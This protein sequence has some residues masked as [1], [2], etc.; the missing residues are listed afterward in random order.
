MLKSLKKKNRIFSLDSISNPKPKVKVDNTAIRSVLECKNL[1]DNCNDSFLPIQVPQ[2]F[3]Q[4]RKVY[5]LD[6]LGTTGKGQTVV[7]YGVNIDEK[8][9]MDSYIGFDQFY[10]FNRP[11]TL[12]IKFITPNQIASPSWTGEALGD[13]QCIHAMAPDAK[14]ILVSLDYNLF[15]GSFGQFGPFPD[16]SVAIQYGLSFKP[17]VFS[18][19]VGWQEED[20][21]YVNYGSGGGIPSF[22]PSF[23]PSLP[24]DQLNYKYFHT[25]TGVDGSERVFE[26]GVKDGIVFVASSG[27]EGA[28]PNYPSTSPNVV[29]VG[30]SMLTTLA[31]NKHL[32]YGTTWSGGGPSTWADK[33]EYQKHI[34]GKFRMTPDVSA[35]GELIWLY[36]AAS[37][38]YEPF[39]YFGVG[40]GTSASA[41]LWAGIL[42]SLN[43]A[44]IK[45]SLQKFNTKTLLSEIY[46]NRQV[47][48]KFYDITKVTNLIPGLAGYTINNGTFQGDPN[49]WNYGNLARFVEQ[50]WDM[51][52]GWGT[53]RYKLLEFLSGGESCHKK[54][55]HKSDCDHKTNTISSFISTL[56]EWPP[57]FSGFPIDSTDT[58]PQ[59]ILITRYQA[60]MIS[61]YNDSSSNIGAGSS[62]ALNFLTSNW[63]NTNFGEYYQFTDP[64][65]SN[66]I[67]T[68]LT[69][70]LALLPGDI[71]VCGSIPVISGVPRAG[72]LYFFASNNVFQTVSPA[73]N[74]TDPF[75]VLGSLLNTFT[76]P[77][78]NGPNGIAVNSK[79]PLNP[80][81]FV[82]NRLTG[83]VVRI[84]LSL[85]INDKTGQAYSVNVK[86]INTVS[87]GF[88]VNGN[89]GPTGITLYKKRLYVADT[90][91]NAIQLIDNIYNQTSYPIAYTTL[92]SGGLLN[93]PYGLTSKTPTKTLICTNID[94]NGASSVPINSI[95]EFDPMTGNVLNSLQVTSDPSVPAG[96]LSGIVA[97]NDYKTTGTAALL[98]LNTYYDTYSIFSSTIPIPFKL[99]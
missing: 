70:A 44:R 89:Y 3:L 73:D 14:I 96:S 34:T 45:N 82:T 67:P 20:T 43:E 61:N 9:V 16:L 95:V 74:F 65:T 62:I 42:A 91:N 56:S 13:V 32:E 90:V 80:I 52:S 71:V 81:L 25:S 12:E 64:I 15:P 7:V 49:H 79:D 6:K 35:T 55:E 68:G 47:Q 59:G 8:T 51:A 98:L 93:G 30:A 1:A 99:R 18:M 31:N 85:G 94:Y 36:I 60:V 69:N 10:G 24:F 37:E 21:Y 26:K 22:D 50:G 58:N 29:S 83:T 54:K 87:S 39:P 41:P 84:D 46:L 23:N 72:S 53:P 17:D 63:L 92:V 33:P 4:L 97:T 75:S 38:L 27:D 2:S 76:S 77:L 19:S 28:L 66:P 40:G 86:S 88:G 5:G 78:L 11:N 57:G 48:N